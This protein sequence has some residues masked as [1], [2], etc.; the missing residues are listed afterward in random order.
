MTGFVDHPQ[1]GRVIVHGRTGATRV[2]A[3]WKEGEPH[4]T[5]PAHATRETVM[6]ILDGLAPRMLARRPALPD[7]RP[8][9]RLEV[10]GLTIEFRDT[11]RHPHGVTARPS[12]PLTY[13]EIGRG[14]DVTALSGASAVSRI[15]RRVAGV[16]AADLLLPRARQLSGE[17]GVAPAEWRI[18][19]GARTLGT[20]HADRSI[21]ISSN[22]VFLPQELRDYIVW[23]ELAHLTEM[24]HGPRFHA[25]CNGYCGGRERE[26][27]RR[28]KMFEW[29]V[30]R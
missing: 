24:N 10:E 28:L 3:R 14:L 2:T 8:G 27:I 21:T 12:L 5:V 22:V 4:L 1:L 18:G 7:F 17:A 25:L 19:R 26:L 15:V 23:H 20:C 11:A 30:M 16:V 29:P 9:T 13:V 6:R